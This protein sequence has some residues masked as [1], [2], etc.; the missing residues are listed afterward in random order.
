MDWVRFGLAVVAVLLLA[1]IAATIY[2]IGHPREPITNG[3][4]GC[5]VSINIIVFVL[6]LLAWQRLG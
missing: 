3:S 4:A 6:L 5:I 2:S 1:G